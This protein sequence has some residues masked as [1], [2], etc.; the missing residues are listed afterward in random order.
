MQGQ[1]IFFFK[2]VINFPSANIGLFGIRQ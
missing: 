1:K 2:L